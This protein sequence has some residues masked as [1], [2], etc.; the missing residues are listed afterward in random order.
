MPILQY[1]CSEC[2]TLFSRRAS[3]V[4]DPTTVC[5]GRACG[6]KRTHRLTRERTIAQLPRREYVQSV[7]DSSQTIADA[8]VKLGLSRHKMYDVISALEIDTS[9]LPRGYSYRPFTDD[10]LFVLHGAKTNHQRP[11]VRD[12][13][14]KKTTDRYYC[15]ECSKPPLWRNKPLTLQMDHV[16]GNPLDNRLDNL[17]WVCPDCH[18]QTDTYVGKKRPT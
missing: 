12:R 14:R 5:C 17:R 16:N 9:N 11:A 15:W 13:F 6:M 3:K 2:K 1:K 8:A 18:S 7:I 10:E 4:R